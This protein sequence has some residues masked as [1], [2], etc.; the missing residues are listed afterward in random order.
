MLE[1]DQAFKGL[2][3]YLSSPSILVAPREKEELLLYVAAMPQ[4]VSAILIIE[5]EEDPRV[6][7]PRKNGDLGTNGSDPGTYEYPGDKNLDPGAPNHPRGYSPDPGE[8]VQHED[9]TKAPMQDRRPG[10]DPS[11]SKLYRTQR[12][13][14]LVSEVLRDAKGVIPPGAEDV[15]HC[16]H[17]VPQAASLLPSSPSHCGQ[18]VPSRTYPPKPRGDGAYSEVSHR[19][20]R[21]QLA[22]CSTSCHQEP[23]VSRLRRRMDPNP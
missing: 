19:V 10:T 2:K 23:S 12:P 17:G 3:S 13:V 5:R 11:I 20:G 16:P 22:V 9:A 1:A 15:V 6:G 8:Q 14:Y 18:L 7:N 4:V 21:V